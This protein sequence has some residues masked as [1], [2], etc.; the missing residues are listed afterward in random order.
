MRAGIIVLGVLILFIAFALGAYTQPFTT[1]SCIYPPIGNSE[2]DTLTVGTIHPYIA[3]ALVVSVIGSICIFW[4]ARAESGEIP[5]PYERSRAT[6][7][8]NRL[9]TENERLKDRVSALE[10]NVPPKPN[11]RVTPPT[12]SSE[13]GG[14]VSHYI[15]PTQVGD[16]EF[17]P[18]V[19]TLSPGV[20]GTVVVSCKE[21]FNA[22]ELNVEGM[23]SPS[24]LIWGDN[25]T[26]A[27][28][29]GRP[30]ALKI[31]IGSSVRQGTYPV[32]VEFYN[33]EEGKKISG[34]FSVSW[35]INRV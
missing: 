30:V 19:L 34:T 11:N 28:Q 29:E 3:D 1:T 14:G 6:P 4:G 21:P 32:E 31:S 15:Q 20:P 22:K 33:K 10:K 24:Q 12:V 5:I 35:R 18:K 16:L 8:E 25:A 17:E 27:I 26:K 7:Y 23:P 9:W 13:L 2:C